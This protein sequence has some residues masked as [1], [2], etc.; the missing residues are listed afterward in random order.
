MPAIQSLKVVHAQEQET[1]QNISIKYASLVPCDV[2]NN[3]HS[4]TKTLQYETAV[5]SIIIFLI[6][7]YAH[8]SV[9]SKNLCQEM[10]LFTKV[11]QICC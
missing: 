3:P 8:E 1:A 2:W 5:C 4:L 9:F 10:V 6:F 7:Q 11:S